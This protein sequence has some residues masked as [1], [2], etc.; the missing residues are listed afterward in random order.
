[1]FDIHKYN[2]KSLHPIIMKSG[3][4]SCYKSCCRWFLLKKKGTGFI[5]VFSFLYVLL[6]TTEVIFNTYSKW[7]ISMKAFCDGIDTKLVWF[8]L[9]SWKYLKYYYDMCLQLL[10]TTLRSRLNKQL[11]NWIW[12]NEYA[13]SS[14]CEYEKSQKWHVYHV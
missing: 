11:Y 14:E 9:L 3:C 7:G 8:G 12:L 5:W 10:T 2:T 4:L 1:M 13:V 6:T